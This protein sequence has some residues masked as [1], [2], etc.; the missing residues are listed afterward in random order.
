[1]RIVP[2][3]EQPEFG[4]GL[5]L[6]PGQDLSG[7]GAAAH[8]RKAGQVRFLHQQQQQQQLT[9]PK[10]HPTLGHQM[11]QRGYAIKPKMQTHI[12][13][14][15]EDEGSGETCEAPGSSLALPPALSD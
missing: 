11:F 12:C 10:M 7:V 1:M 8:V 13:L 6:T 5:P 14:L 3:A 4:W 9:A 2:E 15:G